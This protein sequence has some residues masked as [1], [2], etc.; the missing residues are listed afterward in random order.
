M[1]GYKPL[2]DSIVFRMSGM[3]EHKTPAGIII[4]LNISAKFNDMAHEVVAVSE[5][6]KLD[7]KVG[8]YIVIRTGC[9]GKDLRIDGKHYIHLESFNVL[10]IADPKL[11]PTLPE[12]VFKIDVKQ[13]KVLSNN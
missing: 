4:P 8:D 2:G 11:Y 3:N 1:K 5:N 13:S 10:G 7:I 9:V 6:C 12:E